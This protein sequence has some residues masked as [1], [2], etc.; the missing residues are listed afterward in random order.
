MLLPSFYRWDELGTWSVS[1]GQ[2]ASNLCGWPYLQFW[3]APKSAIWKHLALLLAESFIFLT[4]PVRHGR[5]ALRWNSIEPISKARSHPGCW[6]PCWDNVLPSVSSLVE[7]SRSVCQRLG[8]PSPAHLLDEKT[9]VMAL[10]LLIK[11][12][13]KELELKPIFWVSSSG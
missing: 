8:I 6:L 1:P 5:E 9:I 2:T 10:R 3:L 12:E 13:A 4:W 7:S 11:E